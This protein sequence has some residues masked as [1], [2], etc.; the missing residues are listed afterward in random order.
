M[1][2]H[3]AA[4]QDP[5]LASD[6]V[7]DPFSRPRVEAGELLEVGEDEKGRKLFQLGTGT[8]RRGPGVAVCGSSCLGYRNGGAGAG[9]E[10]GPEGRLRQ[11]LGSALPS[12][13]RQ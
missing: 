3:D 6:V 10:G 13:R 8:T 11:P 4:R 12:K 7:R 2:E 1:S 5:D 9:T